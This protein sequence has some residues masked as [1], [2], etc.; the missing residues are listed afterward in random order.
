MRS[1]ASGSLALSFPWTPLRS[2]RLTPGSLLAQDSQCW[3]PSAR[4]VRECI[5]P[6]PRPLADDN[7]SPPNPTRPWSPIATCGSLP[8]AL[9]LQSR[10]SGATAFQITQIR[11]H[12]PP[13]LDSH[14]WSHRENAS[15]NI[16]SGGSR[17]FLLTGPHTFAARSSGPSGDSPPPLPP[18]PLARSLRLGSGSLRPRRLTQQKRQ[19]LNFLV[20]Q[21]RCPLPPSLSRRSLRS[22]RGLLDR[23]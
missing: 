3:P 19:F 8:S 15:S 23:F 5:T 21:V 17:L 6:D 4:R 18:L 9:V 14:W 11:S 20:V 7:C 2:C 1:P 12:Q 22:A 13:G 16:Q 10:R